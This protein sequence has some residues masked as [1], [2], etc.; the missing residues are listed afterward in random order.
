MQIYAR[1]VHL[2]ARAQRALRTGDADFNYCREEEKARARTHT[3]THMR[4]EILYPRRVGNKFGWRLE[5]RRSPSRVW[6]HPFT[7]NRNASDPRDKYTRY[8]LRRFDD[9]KEA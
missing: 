3:R 7:D 5:S 8:F 1:I 6:P 2:M 4:V 9:L